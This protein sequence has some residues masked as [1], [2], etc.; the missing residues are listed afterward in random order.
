M[1]NMRFLEKESDLNI[2]EYDVR[3]YDFEMYF[4]F[5]SE[6][7]MCFGLSFL[8]VLLV[9]FIFSSD[10][11]VTLLVALSVVVT[12]FFLFGMMWYL[13]L[14]LNQVTVL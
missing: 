3:H 13:G 6:M 12:D 9:V 11:I 14:T 2:F 1:L 8:A 10:I 5:K 7:I 4:T